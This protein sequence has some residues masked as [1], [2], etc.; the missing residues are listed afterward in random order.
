[1]EQPVFL[2]QLVASLTTWTAALHGPGCDL[3]ISACEVAYS[4]ALFFG[5]LVVAVHFSML[6]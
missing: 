5:T 4:A 3:K 1:M 6:D 2:Q